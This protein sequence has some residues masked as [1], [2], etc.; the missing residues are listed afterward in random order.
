MYENDIKRIQSL[1][2][3]ERQRELDRMQEII[4]KVEIT[5]EDIYRI[6]GEA[7]FSSVGLTITRTGR[8]DGRISTKQ[9]MRAVEELKKGLQESGWGELWLK[10]ADQFLPSDVKDRLLNEKTDPTVGADNN[11]FGRPYEG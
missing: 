2:P 11:D 3:E 1:P 7:A 9:A 4:S 10:Y 5:P 6:L 8:G